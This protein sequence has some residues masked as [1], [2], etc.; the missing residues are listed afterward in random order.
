MYY[1]ML[2]LQAGHVYYVTYPELQKMEELM[3]EEAADSKKPRFFLSPI[4]V[5]YVTKSGLLRPIAIQ[6]KQ[7]STGENP[8]WTPGDSEYD[9]L[10]AKMWVREADAQLHQVRKDN[11][12]S[13]K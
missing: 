4:C 6:L 12:P 7:V 11:N 13:I 9:W 2:T 10:T 3:K 1:F 8:I 5:F